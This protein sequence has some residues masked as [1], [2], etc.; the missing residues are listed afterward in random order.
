MKDER[1]YSWPESMLS[2][3]IVSIIWLTLVPAADKMTLRL[4]E[5]RL[6]AQAA[7][8]ASDAVDAHV[9]YGEHEGTLLID[10][11]HFDWRMEGEGICVAYRSLSGWQSLCI[12]P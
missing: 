10:G 11:T 12:A 5:R 7:A 2:L 9:A 1:G 8:A 4:D 3:L 6:A